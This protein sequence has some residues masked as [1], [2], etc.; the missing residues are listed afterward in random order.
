[1]LS[2]GGAALLAIIPEACGIAEVG[3]GS[4]FLDE[5]GT[6]AAADSA[7]GD[8]GGRDDCGCAGRAAVKLCVGVGSAFGAEFADSL[9]AFVSA[10][11]SILALGAGA[12]SPLMRRT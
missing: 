10:G 7:G 2:F 5:F 9:R 8:G 3:A 6:G 1:M 4:D 11:A 12:L